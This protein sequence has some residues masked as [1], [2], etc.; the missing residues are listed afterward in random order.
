[1]SLSL[2]KLED[3]A[4]I[5]FVCEGTN[6]EHIIHWMS[7]SKALKL[8][9]DQYSLEFCRCRTPKGRQR[10][11]RK[12]KEFDYGGPV[13]VA[14]ICDSEKENWK[15]AKRENGQ[16]IPVIH[17]VTKQ[18]IEVLLLL[19]DSKL[20]KEWDSKLKSKVKASAFAKQRFSCDV[21]DGK[22]FKRVFKT[23]DKFVKAC[24]DYKKISGDNAGCLCLY[25]LLNDYYKEP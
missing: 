23:F 9:E 19:S 8:R 18:E 12:I 2:P 15:L 11:S 6:E 1:M 25:D 5:Y 17:I 13:A 10:L 4:F 7:D 22:I 14:Y 16:D 3:Y 24:R 21:K 20:F